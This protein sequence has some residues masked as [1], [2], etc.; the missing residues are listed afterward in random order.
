MPYRQVARGALLL[1]A[2]A[3][4]VCL[5][6]Y[7]ATS[8]PGSW[9]PGASTQVI[10]ARAFTVNRGTAMP[11]GDAIAISATDASGLALIAANVEAR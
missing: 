9:F 10:G 2:A 4:V 7:L 3:F 11:D 1:F 5:V 8:V 6:A